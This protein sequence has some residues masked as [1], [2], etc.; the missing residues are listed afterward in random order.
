MFSGLVLLTPQPASSTNDDELNRQLMNLLLERRGTSSFLLHSTQSH[1][2]EETVTPRTRSSSI[3]GEKPKEAASAEKTPTRSPRFSK[4]NMTKVALEA[5]WDV[6]NETGRLFQ[7]APSTRILSD[8]MV[9]AT[10]DADE[11]RRRRIA[12][13]TLLQK[14][15]DSPISSDGYSEE[16]MDL[17]QELNLDF[18]LSPPAPDGDMKTHLTMTQEKLRSKIELEIQQHITPREEAPSPLVRDLSMRF[19]EIT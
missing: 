10:V 14:I 11:R 2:N 7:G 17:I 18:M 15:R 6:V 1:A 8:A 5:V 16:I 19:N 9:S 3:D 13:E 4:E 12:L